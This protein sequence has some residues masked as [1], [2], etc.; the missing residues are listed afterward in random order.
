[1]QWDPRRGFVIPSHSFVPSG[2]LMCSAHVNGSV[3]NS[4]YV[5]QRLG[6]CQGWVSAREQL[7]ASAAPVPSLLYPHLCLR[8]LPRLHLHQAQ[9]GMLKVNSSFFFFF[10]SY[11]SIESG[12]GPL[13]VLNNDQVLRWHRTGVFDSNSTKALFALIELYLYWALKQ[14]L[15]FLLLVIKHVWSSYKNLTTL[16]IHI[17]AFYRFSPGDLLHQFPWIYSWASAYN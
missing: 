6:E 15:S 7:R 17:F 3:F 4:Y 9:A 13:L 12:L 5:A 11:Y 16:L 1:M 8:H 2:I 10:F 14:Q